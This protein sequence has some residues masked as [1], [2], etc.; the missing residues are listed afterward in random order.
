[1]IV[2]SVFFIF[3]KASKEVNCAVTF[4]SKKNMYIIQ[5]QMIIFVTAFLVKR[6]NTK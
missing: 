3:K 5:V 6:K 4:L 2:V 1:M